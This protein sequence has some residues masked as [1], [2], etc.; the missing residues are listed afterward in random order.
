[1]FSSLKTSAIRNFATTTTTTVYRCA[2]NDLVKTNPSWYR[3]LTAEQYQY[4]RPGSVNMYSRE[5]LDGMRKAGKLA[6]NTL[7][8]VHSIIKPN[9][10]T[11]D[12]HVECKNFIEKNNGVASSIGFNGFPASVCT[13]VNEVACHGIPKK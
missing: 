6:A 5:A 13:S 10:T 3:P 9:I 12:I 8:H 7:R 11:Q 2:P 4:Y 1:M